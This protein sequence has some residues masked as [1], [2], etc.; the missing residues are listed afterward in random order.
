MNV[1]R[2]RVCTGPVCSRRMSMH[3]GAVSAEGK[4]V[5]GL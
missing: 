3:G 5:L 4:H 1:H 2:E